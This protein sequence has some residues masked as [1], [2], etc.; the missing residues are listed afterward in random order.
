LYSQIIVVT[1][2]EEFKLIYGLIGFVVHKGCFIFVKDLALQNLHAQRKRKLPED[3]D[4][5]NIV[6]EIR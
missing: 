1:A 6:K 3:L 5:I 4:V 2:F